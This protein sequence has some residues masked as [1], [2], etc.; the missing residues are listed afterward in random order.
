MEFASNV[1]SC[2]WAR[3]CPCFNCRQNTVQTG[4]R[5][6][7]KSSAELCQD[8]IE[9]KS[10]MIPALKN[11]L[12]DVLGQQPGNMDAPNFQ[13]KPGDRAAASSL[14]VLQFYKLLVLHFLSML[15]TFVP[16]R[17]LMGL[18]L[19]VKPKLLTI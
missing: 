10:L 3:N 7:R 11:N 16:L 8:Y 18:T 13:M 15:I 14:C 1:A 9:M 17:S 6:N 19:T 2:H 12:S 5:K 4:Q